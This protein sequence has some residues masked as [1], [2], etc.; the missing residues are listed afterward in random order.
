MSIIRKLAGTTWGAREDV[1]R[2]STTALVLAP[3]EYC[4][5]VWSSSHHTKLVDVE[6]HAAMRLVTGCW[7]DTPLSS[8]EVLAGIPPPS[9]RR[10]AAVLKASWKALADPG[11]LL[12][13]YVIRQ[14]APYRCHSQPTRRSPRVHPAAPQQTENRRLVSRRPFLLASQEL[15]ASAADPTPLSKAQRHSRAD[16]YVLSQWTSGWADEARPLALYRSPQ[17]RPPGSGLDR[18]S[19]CKVNRL[20]TGCGPF[21]ENLHKYGMAADSRCDCGALHQTAIHIVEECPLHRLAGGMNDL[22][23]I[24][25]TTSQWLKNLVLR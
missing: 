18:D 8:L 6:I 19:W 17:L 2:I 3:A 12:H 10:D 15:R 13:E 16:S 1:L 22:A 14:P 9:L 7:K 11:S 5:A 25:E 20:L 4:A 21:A 23:T 24:D